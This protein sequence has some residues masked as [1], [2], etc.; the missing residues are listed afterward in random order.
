[1]KYKTY[2]ADKEGRIC[3]YPS[4]DVPGRNIADILRVFIKN[5]IDTARGKGKESLREE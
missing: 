1:M 3:I 5:L 2:E 4:I